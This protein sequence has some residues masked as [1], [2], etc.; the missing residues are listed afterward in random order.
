MRPLNQDYIRLLEACID[1]Y[2]VQYGVA[3]TYSEISRVTGLA[4]STINRYL[5]HMEQQGL[6]E[7]GGSR[8]I[9]TRTAKQRNCTIRMLPLSGQIAC[10]Q[11]RLALE[12][13]ECY[14]PV[15]DGLLGSGSYFLLRASGDSMIN[16]GIQDGDL[17]LIRQQSHA[18]PGQ[19]VIALT[20]E[21]A[22][23]KRYYPEPEL[24]RIRLH[25]ENDALTDIYVTDCII[26]G[27]AIKSL[28]I[29][30]LI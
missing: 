28:H 5:K 6:L 23:L 1:D 27:V 4:K 30:D 12:Q 19:I 13:I 17:V 15:P 8:N 11:P 21:E 24:G 2:R 20:E 10:G 26:Q 22:T 29:S 25:P 14:L 18:E 16:A 9:L 3:P 7:L